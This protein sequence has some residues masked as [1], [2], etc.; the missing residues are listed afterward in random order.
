MKFI[1][2]SVLAVAINIANGQNPY[3]VPDFHLQYQSLDSIPYFYDYDWYYATYDY[4]NLYQYDYLHKGQL[5]SFMK[6]LPCKEKLGVEFQGA[7]LQIDQHGSPIYFKTG[8]FRDCAIVCGMHPDCVMYTYI[9]DG[10]EAPGCYLKKGAGFIP[11]GNVN[12]VSGGG[13]TEAKYGQKHQA[14]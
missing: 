10:G 11:V 14:Q 6:E 13:C 3:H 1:L 4:E 12:A 2:L 8:S 9:N 5:H 7:D